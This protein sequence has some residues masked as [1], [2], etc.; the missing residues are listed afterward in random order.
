MNTAEETHTKSWRPI[1]ERLLKENGDHLYGIH[2][3]R[4]QS[5]LL[6]ARNQG[7]EKLMEE[8]LMLIRIWR[9]IKRKG[10]VYDKLS[11]DE[12]MEAQDACHDEYEELFDLGDEL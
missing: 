6:M 3:G 4:Y 9:G 12:L 11:P 2:I 7:N 10:F 1:Y 5:R 8:N